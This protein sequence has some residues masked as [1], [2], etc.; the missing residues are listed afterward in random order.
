MGPRGSNHL[1]DLPLCFPFHWHEALSVRVERHFAVRVPQRFLYR[2]HVFTIPFQ[3]SGKR[4]P[5]YVPAYVLHNPGPFCSRPNVFC[6]CRA[7]PQRLLALFLSGCEDVIRVLIV[8]TLPAP[9]Q[10]HWREALNHFT[11]LWSERMPALD[12]VGLQD[13]G[14]VGAS[15]IRERTACSKAQWTCSSTFRI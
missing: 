3:E 2:L 7:R 5:E 8:K 14:T 4:V 1:N 12:R 9:V 6:H 13:E 10:Y 15:E 11:I